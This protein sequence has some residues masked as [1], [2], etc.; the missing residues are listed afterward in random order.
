[1]VLEHTEEDTRDDVVAAKE[2][3]VEAWLAYR[4]G[5]AAVCGIAR[6]TLGSA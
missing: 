4:D 1:V 2:D 6:D 3:E 5:V